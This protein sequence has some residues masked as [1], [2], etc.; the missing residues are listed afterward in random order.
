MITKTTIDTTR[1]HSAAGWWIV[2]GAIMGLLAWVPIIMAAVWL[3]SPVEGQIIDHDPGG[4]IGA[5][6]ALIRTSGPVEIRGV[7]ASACTMH[8]SNGC[9]HPQAHLIFHGPQVQEPDAFE[10]WSAVM[11][12]HYPPA[13]REWFMQS[14]RY[15][16]WDMTGSSAIRMGAEP[17]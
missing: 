2:P 1:P 7:C 4:R 10:H 9:V 12:R 14:G 13:I 8:L 15:G 11:A 6:A 16:T 5:R 17:C 3:L